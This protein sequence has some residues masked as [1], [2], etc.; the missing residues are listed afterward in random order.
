M[1]AR[2]GLAIGAVAAAA[3]FF[4][5]GLVFKDQGD[6]AN[7]YL[8]EQLVEHGIA[9]TP[10]ANLMPAQQKVPCMVKNAGKMLTTGKQAECYARYQI[11]LDLPLVA[12]GKTYFQAHYN[13]YLSRVK[14][15]QALKTAP[16]APATEELLKAATQADRTADDLLAGESMRGLL[17]TG[18]GFSV[19][20]DK[21]SQAGVVCF[22][23]APLMLLVGIVLVLRPGKRPVAAA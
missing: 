17:L 19:I 6:F 1:T 21:A 23:L 8:K 16:N 12:N 13:G 22:V 10:V 3:I 14:A 4:F 18:Y 20:G 5:L 11:G 2:R 7:N 9:F 15:Q